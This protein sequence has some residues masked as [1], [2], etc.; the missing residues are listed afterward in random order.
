MTE[1]ADPP[2]EGVITDPFFQILNDGEWNACIGKQSD[3]L[4]Y[5][6]GYLQSAQLLVDTLIKDELLGQRD[7]LVLPILYNVRH[8]LELALKFVLDE[9]VKLDLARPRKLADSHNLVA[10][11]RHLDGEQIGDRQTR[12]LIAE[13]RPYVESLS[14][15]DEDGQRLRY[16]MSRSGEQSL[17][18]QAV[19]NLR[20]IQASVQALRNIV[21]KLI[22]RMCRLY[23]EAVTGTRTNCCSRTDLV[24]IAQMVGPRRSWSDEGFAERKAEVRVRFDLSSTAFSKALNAIQASRELQVLLE[25]ETPLLYLNPQLVQEVAS[26]WLE[27]QPARRGPAKVI[28][29]TKVDIDAFLAD[30]DGSIARLAT[31]VRWTLDSLTVEQFADLQTIFY[32]GRNDEFGEQYARNVADTLRAHQLDSGRIAQIHHIMSKTNFTEGL[33]RGLERIGQPALATTIANLRSEARTR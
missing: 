6:E 18:D 25:V 31:L 19:A 30:E 8:G 29:L 24:E 27:A 21:D 22:D 11:W 4:N 17:G 15:I 1:M 12:S 3:E 28:D 13:L 26:R 32:L 14:K 20:L 23:L 5:V 16:F 33:L 2:N 10:Y 7:K 9:L